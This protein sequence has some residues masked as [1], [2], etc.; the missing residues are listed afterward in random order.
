MWW[1]LTY[2]MLVFSSLNG[3]GRRVNTG[4]RWLGGDEN[5]TFQ[6][7]ERLL[8]PCASRG[9]HGSR[10][11][12]PLHKSNTLP[13]GPTY[14]QWLLFI[15]LS[16]PSTILTGKYAASG[17]PCCRVWQP[18]LGEPEIFGIWSGFRTK[19]THTHTLRNSSLEQVGQAWLPWNAFDKHCLKAD[20]LASFQRTMVS[21]FFFFFFF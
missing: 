13:L 11:L 17:L 12:L 20:L 16:S 4:A 6:K 18:T 10:L 21:V 19:H 7:A 15:I 2:H 8:C 1:N 9:Q 5:S 14:P 3:S